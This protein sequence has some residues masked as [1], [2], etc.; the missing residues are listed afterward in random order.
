MENQIGFSIN[1]NLNFV[2]QLHRNDYSILLK[3]SHLIMGFRKRLK[4]QKFI[5]KLTLNKK[6]GRLNMIGGMQKMLKRIDEL[7]EQITQEA[8]LN[9]RELQ[10]KEMDETTQQLDEYIQNISEIGQQLRLVTDFVNHIRKSLLRVEGKINQIKEQLNNM[11]ND[12]KFLRG[13]SVIQLLEIRKWK[14]LKEAAEKNVKSIYVPSKTQGKGKNEISNL[15][16]LDQF[17]DQNGE[18]NEFLYEGKTVLLIH[19]LAGIG[20]STTAIKIEE[21][22]WKLHDSNQKIGNYVLIPVYISLPSLKTLFF[23][24]QRNHLNKMIM[25]LMISN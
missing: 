7:Q 11:G 4:S 19:G 5:E 10:L 18:V 2:K 14:V 13:K 21:F 22:I 16:I 20:K 17:G 8:N 15:M 12:L 6:I 25:D 23:K 3:N 1:Y 24:Q 9:K